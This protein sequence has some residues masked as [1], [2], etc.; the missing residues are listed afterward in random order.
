MS[1]DPVSQIKALYYGATAKTIGKDLQDAIA[2]LKTLE[3]EEERERAAVFMDG[4]AQM[5]SEWALERSNA[6]AVRPARDRRLR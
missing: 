3:T 1:T 4:L 2:L 5:R 6:P